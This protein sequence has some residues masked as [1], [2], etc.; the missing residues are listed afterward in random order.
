MHSFVANTQYF[1][2]R[3]SDNE[4]QFLCIGVP[5]KN[6]SEGYAAQITS[7]GMVLSGSEK[8]EEGYQLLKMLADTEHWQFSEMPVNR[9]TIEMMLGQAISM[10]Y[11]FHPSI[12]IGLPAANKEPQFVSMLTEE[13]QAEKWYG[14][15]YAIKPLSQDT[16]DYLLYMIDHIE[17]ANLPEYQLAKAVRK[18][19]EEYI[20]GDTETMEQAYENAISVLED[21]GYRK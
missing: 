3:F 10:Q 5:S 14:D 20:W 15:G 16:A 13:S 21:M 17:T 12:S 6:N 2:S 8:A 9:N 11:M 18:E 7:F 19:M 1:E 4:E